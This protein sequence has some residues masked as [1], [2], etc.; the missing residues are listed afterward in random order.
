MKLDRYEHTV[1]EGHEDTQG[2]Y[3]LKKELSGIAGA[4]KAL[5][6]CG[7][8]FTVIDMFCNI[9]KLALLF[10]PDTQTQVNEIDSFRGI[11]GLAL[12]GFYIAEVIIFC[13]WV[14]RAS[15]NCHHFIASNRTPSPSMRFSPGW[16]VGCW[17]VPF[18]NLW[19]PYQVIKEIWKVSANPASW[20]SEEGSALLVA[21]W[22]L[23]LIGNF[24]FT[25]SFI[26]SP[27]AD[28]IGDQQSLTTINIISSL[29]GIPFIV[30]EIYVISIITKRQMALASHSKNIF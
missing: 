18:L 11:F 8:G 4:L 7:I 1:P 27:N 10:A 5:M 22:T 23:T 15:V 12:C 29:E 9:A 21:Y 14:H 25:L 26:M 19:R 28:S 16:A 20:K 24:L 30:V 17:F 2:K 3:T 13:I 6:W